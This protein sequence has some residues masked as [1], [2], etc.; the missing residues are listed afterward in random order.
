MGL[1]DF[2]CD[3]EADTKASLVCVTN[4]VFLCK[5]HER[6]KNCLPSTG[7]A[8]GQHGAGGSGQRVVVVIFGGVRRA[9]TFSLRR[10]QRSRR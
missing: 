5:T 8:G 4:R 2:A 9:E 3:V 1:H 10:K 7:V 6:F